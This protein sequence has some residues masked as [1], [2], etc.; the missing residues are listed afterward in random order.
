MSV[1]SSAASKA[2]GAGAT[3][4]CT[5][6][7]MPTAAVRWWQA[8]P[9]IQGWGRGRRAQ[10]Q[11]W[12]P[13]CRWWCHLRWRRLQVRRLQPER[14]LQAQRRCQGAETD[15]QA[16]GTSWRADKRS[17]CG[18]HD[19]RWR[20]NLDISSWRLQAGRRQRSASAHGAVPDGLLAHHHERR[21][22]DS[23]LMYLRLRRPGLVLVVMYCLQERLCHLVEQGLQL[24]QAF[25]QVRQTLRADS[26]LHPRP[27]AAAFPECGK[28]C[29]GFD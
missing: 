13:H 26:T 20:G 29:V 12:R 19:G 14:L 17:R 15:A 24:R 3:N 4:G 25:G 2:R 6:A 1:S 9:R 5:A 28:E 11:S 22:L 10:A 23:T 21:H 16:C 18:S 7:E 27:A 8:P